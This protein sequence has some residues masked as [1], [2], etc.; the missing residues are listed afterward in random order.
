MVGEALETARLNWGK[1]RSAADGDLTGWYEALAASEQARKL[2]TQNEPVP[3]ILRSWVDRLIA[4][5]EHERDAAMQRANER[6]EDVELLRRLDQIRRDTGIASGS[7][8][9]S[10]KHIDATFARAFRGFGVDVDRID[11]TEAGRLLRRRSKPLE[12]A[13]YLEDWAFAHRRALWIND[14]V[15]KDD[16]WKRLVRVSGIVDSDPW[17]NSLRSLIGT[18]SWA[19]KP[20]DRGTARGDPY[21]DEVRLLLNL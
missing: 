3:A 4:D 20:R 12:I 15:P 7:G 6:D 18:A 17:R 19:D 21:Q 14:M 16:S 5:L 8:G 10:A 1:A 9:A 2:L 13:F 11:P